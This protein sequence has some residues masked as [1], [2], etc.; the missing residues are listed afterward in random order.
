MEL[1]TE[2]EIEQIFSMQLRNKITEVVF[3][4]CRSPSAGY[5]IS[6]S[7]IGSTETGYLVNKPLPVAC[8]SGDKWITPEA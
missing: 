2:F 4:F 8:I 7:L 1:R 6:N 3:S 5:W